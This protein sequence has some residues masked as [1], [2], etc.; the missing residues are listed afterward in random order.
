MKISSSLLIFFSIS[1]FLLACKS[2]DIHTEES[3]QDKVSVDNDDPLV[4]IQSINKLLQTNAKDYSL[5]ESRS[6]AYYQIDSLGKALEDINQAIELFPEGHDLYFLKG[7]YAFAVGDTQSAFKA[8]KTSVGLGSTN[9]E[10]YYQLGQLYFFSQQWDSAR[11]LYERAHQIQEEEPQYLFA[12]GFLLEDQNSPREAV[13]FYLNAIALD[14]SFAKAYMRLHDIYLLT[15]E[16]EIEAMKYN[17]LLLKF[18]PTHPL[19]QY[20]LGNDFFRKAI[21]ITQESRIPEF[22][23]NINDA[24]TAYTIALNKDPNFYLAWYGRAYCYFIG[25]NR[26]EEAIRDLQKTL[27]L[28]PNYAPAH[29][30]LGSIYEQSGDLSSALSHYELA[31]QQDN[32]NRDFKKA[33]D[34]IRAQL[35]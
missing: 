30:T 35:N 29:F 3:N 17:N 2:N 16:N 9:P 11:L 12:Q 33:V 22:K 18:Q 4:Q 10:S 7:F 27:E 32:N 19:A 5:Y 1:L 15:Y 21:R 8:L 20:N 13:K 26:M 28:N 6:E 14:S 34:E 24:V 31:F 23:Q 25:E